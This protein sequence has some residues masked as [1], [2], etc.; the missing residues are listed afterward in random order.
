MIDR[1][2][3]LNCDI[4]ILFVWVFKAIPHNTSPKTK[5]RGKCRGLLCKLVSVQNESSR[6]AG[7]VSQDQICQSKQH[8][9]FGSLL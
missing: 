2:Q 6:Q 3:Q 7:P 5:K 4:V 9:Q 8:I 1:R